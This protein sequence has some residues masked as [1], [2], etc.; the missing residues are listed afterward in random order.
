MYVGTPPQHFSAAVDS[1]SGSLSTMYS[2]LS[3]VLLS[4]LMVGSKSFL[5]NLCQIG[6]LIVPAIT[7]T[8]CHPENTGQ[9]NPN[10]SSSSVV[11]SR[12]HF[13]KQNWFIH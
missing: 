6:D 13:L 3:S 2:S 11:C 10:D 4:V 12:I 5:F 7:C 1:G 9:Y 8:G